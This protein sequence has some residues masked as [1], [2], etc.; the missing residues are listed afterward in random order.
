MIRVGRHEISQK[1]GLRGLHNLALLIME[2]VDIVEGQE[3]NL[4]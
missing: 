3:A 1:R 2:L 4:T